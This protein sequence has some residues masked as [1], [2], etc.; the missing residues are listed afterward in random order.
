[1][2][3][4]FVCRPHAAAGA[5]SAGKIRRERIFARDKGGAGRSKQLRRFAPP[6]RATASRRVIGCGGIRPPFPARKL[7]SGCGILRLSR[8]RAG[9]LTP[10][11]PR[12]SMK[13]P[14]AADDAFRLK[15]AARWAACCSWRSG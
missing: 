10:D 2:S 6:R 7:A 3:S 15:N 5:F 9:R 13:T 14:A 11:P 12:F 8:Y 4:R 1:L